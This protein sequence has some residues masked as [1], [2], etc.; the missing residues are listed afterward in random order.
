MN[1]DRRA[2]N[3]AAA[4]RRQARAGLSLAGFSLVEL[5]IAVLILSVGVLGLAGTTGYVVRSITLADLNTERAAALQSAMERIR[6]TPF[7]AL[8]DGADTVGNFELTWEVTLAGANVRDVRIIS[9]GPGLSGTGTGMPSIVP[10][11]A[12]TFEYT[13]VRP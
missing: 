2:A 13:V 10:N 5:V 3:R 7:G 6:A 4:A 12:D 11:A 1:T 9:V 8:S